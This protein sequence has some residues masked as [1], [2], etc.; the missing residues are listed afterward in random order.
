MVMFFIKNRK[1]KKKLQDPKPDIIRIH[2][3]KRDII[4]AHELFILNFGN[5][6]YM[7]RNGEYSEYIQYKIPKEVEQEWREVLK[8]QLMDILMRKEIAWAVGNLARL[9]IKESEILDCF[10]KLA[11]SQNADEIRDTVIKLESNIPPDIFYKI[12]RIMTQ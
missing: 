12:K 10:Q 2:D 3:P 1:K 5:Y 4:R 11:K 8:D 9:Q 6:N 7:E